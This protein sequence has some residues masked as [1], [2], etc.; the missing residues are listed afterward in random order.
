MDTAPGLVRLGGEIDYTV[1]PQVREA[2][3]GAVRADAGPVTLD[4][5]D[6][7]YLDSSGL[8]VFIE[9]R[10]FLKQ[11]GRGLELTNLQDPVRKVFV[12]TQVQTLFGIA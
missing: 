8:A 10:K 12:L 9:L 4:L 3:L 1:T 7:E 5:T 2:L 11:Q 6:L